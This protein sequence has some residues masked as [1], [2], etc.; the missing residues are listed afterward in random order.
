MRAVHELARGHQLSLAE[1]GCG[2]W[3]GSQALCPLGSLPWSWAQAPCLHPP[4]SSHHLSLYLPHLGQRLFPGDTPSCIAFVWE[5]STP[6]A[7]H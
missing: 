6:Q 7:A 3:S 4:S 5:P 2:P 1:L